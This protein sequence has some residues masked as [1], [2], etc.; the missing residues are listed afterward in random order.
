[1]QFGTDTYLYR[2]GAG[3]LKTNGHLEA[4]SIVSGSVPAAANHVTRK[5]YV[6]AQVAT[7]VAVGT[8][9]NRAYTRDGTGAETMH[10]FA[11]TASA[12]SLVYRTTGG[13]T[14]VGTPTAA[15]HAATKDYVDTTTVASYTGQSPTIWYGTQAAYDAL[16]S[17][18]KNAAGFVAVITP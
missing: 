3:Q 7:R 1:M 14:S 16:A 9:I 11:S 6:D 10:P 15:D 8:G 2:M 17:G 12:F 4:N 18:T 13:V 5:D